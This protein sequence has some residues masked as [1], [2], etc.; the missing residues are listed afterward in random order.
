MISL[1]IFLEGGRPVIFSQV[2]F[3]YGGRRFVMYKFRKFHHNCGTNALP[4]T[5]ENDRRM[6]RLGVHREPGVQIKYRPLP[7]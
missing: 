3:G 2:R 6:T 4:L 7:R 5:M 1:A